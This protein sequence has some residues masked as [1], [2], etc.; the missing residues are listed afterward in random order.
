[1]LL[2]GADTKATAAVARETFKLATLRRF[3]VAMAPIVGTYRF[4]FGNQR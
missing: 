3:G 1:V 2:E 4:I